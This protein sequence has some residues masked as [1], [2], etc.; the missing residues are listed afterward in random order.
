MGAPQPP[1]LVDRDSPAPMATSREKALFLQDSGLRGPHVTAWGPSGQGQSQLSLPDAPE[2]R[3][4]RGGHLDGYFGRLV[5]SKGWVAGSQAPSPETSPVPCVAADEHRGHRDPG[6]RRG[7]QMPQGRLA[8]PPGPPE[9]SL[10]PGQDARKESDGWTGGKRGSGPP[11]G[12]GGRGNFL[13]RGDTLL[14]HAL[15]RRCS[16]CHPRH[17]PGAS[18]QRTPESSPALSPPG[19]WSGFWTVLTN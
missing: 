14:L 12:G 3:E 4:S 15:T 9:L 8:Y 5:T 1:F 10:T 6:G 17:S 19:G 2:M 16:V 11:E 7:P 13:G 18:G